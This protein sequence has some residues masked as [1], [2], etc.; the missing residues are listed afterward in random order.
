MTTVAV[1]C[2]SGRQSCLYWIP[3]DITD[4]AEELLT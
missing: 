4:S 1:L 3:E 2:W